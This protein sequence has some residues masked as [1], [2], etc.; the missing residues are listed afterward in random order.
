[1]LFN[2][3]LLRILVIPFTFLDRRISDFKK[4]ALLKKREDGNF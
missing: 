2:L 3:L 1:L 4:E